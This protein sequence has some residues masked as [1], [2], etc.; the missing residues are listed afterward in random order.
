MKS[1]TS[2]PI[3]VRSEIVINASGRRASLSKQAKL[4]AGFTRFGV[5]AEYD[6]SA[7]RCNQEEALLIVGSRYAPAVTPGS[8]LGGRIVYAWAPCIP[9]AEP[10][11]KIT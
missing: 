3:D 6:L 5:G 4:H 2:G 9:I 1:G 10:I 11:Q 7:P 8:S